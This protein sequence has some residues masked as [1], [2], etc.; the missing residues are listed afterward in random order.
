MKRFLV[1]NGDDFGISSKVNE[2]IRIAHTE[3]ILTSA[4]IMPSGPAFDEAVSISKKYPTLAI[5][6][7]LSLNWGTSCLPH[8]SIT[9]LISEDGYFHRHYMS[10][11]LLS[12]SSSVR[13]QMYLE[14]DEQIR[15]TISNG[16][17]PDHLDSQF[18]IH[19]FP[20]IFPIIQNLAIKYNIH[21]IRIPS[22][23]LHHLNPN[24]LHKW[25]ALQLSIKSS[26]KLN[27]HVDKPYE[28]FGII[29]SNNMNA[30]NIIRNLKNSRKK[31]V[32]LSTHPAKQCK[33]IKSFNFETQGIESFISHPA[34]KIER[35]A[36]CSP[37]LRKFIE[38]NNWVLTTFGSIDTKE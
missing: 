7:H 24:T 12:F 15:K 14:F 30:D 20:T 11:I 10:S 31:Y 29:H 2:G 38:H 27:R 16:I 32:E 19:A 3:G 18:H 8:S 22:E 36:L 34:R 35:E 21:H 17:K 1:I 9:N 5:G 26:M 37:K 13:R 6:V 33:D 25:L 4:S 28:Y 23:S